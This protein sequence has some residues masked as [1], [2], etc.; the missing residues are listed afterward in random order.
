[1]TMSDPLSADL[2]PQILN[3]NASI[4]LVKIVNTH[5]V[6]E[7]DADLPVEAGLVTFQVLEVFRSPTLA[8]S[9]TIQVPAR[10][11][12]DPLTRFRN[13]F[14]QWNNLHLEVG[15]LLVLA[16][17]PLQPPSLWTGLAAKPVEGPGGPQLEALRRCIALEQ[18]AGPPERKIELLG[19]ALKSK[20]DLLRYYA[21]EVLASGKACT[22]ERAAELMAAAIASPETTAPHKLE[23]GSNLTRNAFFNKDDK[24]AGVNPIVVAALAQGLVAETDIPRRLS[25]ARYLASCTLG[26]FA[27]DPA[28]DLKIRRSL[29]RKAQPP[30]SVQVIKA[31]SDVSPYAQDDEREIVRNL[32]AAWKAAEAETR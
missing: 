18:F 19:D 23:L 13:N 22:R 11:I 24:A 7:P 26:Q 27:D 1:V 20:E 5:L 16:C 6:R 32:L 9:N 25:W 15:N 31:L 2:V 29:I 17:Q 10:R 21:I 4:V 30:P 12:A 14:D 3:K 8:P 28:E